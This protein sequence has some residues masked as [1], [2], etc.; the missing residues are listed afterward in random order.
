MHEEEQEQ[1]EEPDHD[2]ARVGAG[3]EVLLIHEREENFEDVDVSLFE[4]TSQQTFM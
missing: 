3:V 1:I 2:P 4:Y